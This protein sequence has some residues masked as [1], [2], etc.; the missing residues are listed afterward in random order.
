MADLR[1]V[2]VRQPNGLKTIGLA[3]GLATVA[4]GTYLAILLNNL[5]TN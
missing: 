3:L 2:E 5:P 4:A 1:N